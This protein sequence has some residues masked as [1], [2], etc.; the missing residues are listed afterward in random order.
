MVPDV[1]LSNWRKW[2]SPH[3]VLIPTRCSCQARVTEHAIEQLVNEPPS[4]YPIVKFPVPVTDFDPGATQETC[5]LALTSGPR[6]HERLDRRNW[7][8]ESLAADGQQAIS[9]SACGE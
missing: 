5:R 1:A 2:Q 6:Q 8:T 9:A 4:C 3:A 7:P